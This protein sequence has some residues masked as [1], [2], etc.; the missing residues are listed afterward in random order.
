M[1]LAIIPC[2]KD[3]SRLHKKNVQVLNGRTLLERACDIAVKAV[4]TGV[5]DHVVVSYDYYFSELDKLSSVVIKEMRPESLR[6]NP[7]HTTLDVAKEVLR[8]RKHAQNICLLIP[9]SPLRTLRHIVQSRMLMNDDSDRV[10][11]SLL[12]YQQDPNARLIVDKFGKIV[13]VPVPPDIFCL[14]RIPYIHCGTVLWAKAVWA[15]NAQSWYDSSNI[16]PYYVDSGFAWDVNDYTDLE[17]SR[18][19][20][21]KSDT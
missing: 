13:R 4:E 5:F 6:N 1:N 3:S 10:V 17:I 16:V 19:L 18:G 11:M 9:A 8:S 7:N 12:K 2:K 21:I 14:N 15:T 20:N